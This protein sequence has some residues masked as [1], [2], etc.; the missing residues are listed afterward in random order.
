MDIEAGGRDKLSA[1]QQLGRQP[2]CGLCYTL[3]P[4]DMALVPRVQPKALAVGVPVGFYR[5]ADISSGMREGALGLI[6]R[7][8]G[9]SN[10]KAFLECWGRV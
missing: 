6:Y 3:A 10:P 7:A 1:T 4:E 9:Q 8:R 5:E 2:L